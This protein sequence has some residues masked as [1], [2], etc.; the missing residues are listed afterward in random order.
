MQEPQPARPSEPPPFK[1]V[2]FKAAHMAYGGSQA[3]GQIEAV[4]AT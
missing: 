1:F 4:A 2:F 3:R